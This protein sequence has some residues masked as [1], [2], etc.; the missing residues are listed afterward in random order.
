VSTLRHKLT[1]GKS[2]VLRYLVSWLPGA[3]LDFP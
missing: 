1:V 3:T 2:R